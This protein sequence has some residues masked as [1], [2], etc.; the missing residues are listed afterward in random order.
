[1]TKL[2]KKIKTLKC[3]IEIG[4]DEIETNNFGKSVY[5]HIVANFVKSEYSYVFLIEGT[6]YGLIYNPPSFKSIS[7]LA[8]RSDLLWFS[9]YTS[10]EDKIIIDAQ[11]FLSD[12]LELLD[13]EISDEIIFNLD[14]VS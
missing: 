8:K 5:T 1:M 2:L 3:L 14:V 11:V 10:K 6:I 7:R 13:E 4:E 9:Y 12:I